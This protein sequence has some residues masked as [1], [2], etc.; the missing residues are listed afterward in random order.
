[1]GNRAMNDM[2]TQKKDWYL[3]NFE[4]FE[5]S[6]N[7]EASSHLHGIRRAA[8]ARFAEVGF[9]TTRN[10]EWKYTDVSPIA[11][12]SFKPVLTPHTDGLA[13]G[14]LERF[15]LGNPQWNRLVCVNGQYSREL[16]SIHQHPSGLVIAS[17]AEA[18]RKYPDAVEKHLARHA[19]F[20]GDGFTALSTAF[21][22]DGAFVFIPDGV[23]FKE[24]IHL[25]FV[26]TSS[27]IEFVCQPRNLIIAGASCQ[28]AIV[29][30]HVSLSDN[31]YFTNTVSEMVLGE[32]TI[33]EYERF[34]DQSNRSFHV[35]TL[36]VQQERNSHFTSNSF[37]FGGI[38][39]RNNITA[40]LDG[41][42]GEATLNGLYLGTEKQHIDNHTT[43]DHTKPHCNSHELYKGILHGT[44]RGVFNG[45]IVVRKD[46]QKTDAKQTN[47]NLVLSDEASIDTKPQLEIYANDVKCTHG[48]T[49]G[50]LDEEA[51]FYLRSR[52]VG[53]DKARDILIYAFASDVISRCKVESLREQL[54]Y[55]L[56]VRLE[57][58]RSI[59]VPS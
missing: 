41:E 38:L 31:V 13:T 28:A 45:K 44:S 46:A 26:S 17:L 39:V 25:I 21:M 57:R 8:I 7:G 30:S 3:S 48:A 23:V 55:L 1:M 12:L 58:S 14:V 56:H 34:Q 32:N 36:H 40:V 51:I 20:E 53:L 22:Q 50:Q 10:E 49:V 19:R 2:P 6:L 4:I 37:S 35:S 33:I 11:S 27:E 52:G 29:E 9:P 18:I 59:K 24:P 5:K 47:K 42:G 15:T 43:I 54:H 16:S